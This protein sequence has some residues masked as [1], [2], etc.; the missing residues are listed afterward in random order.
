MGI[1]KDIALFLG[2]GTLALVMP[3]LGLPQ[4]AGWLRGRGARVSAADLNAVFLSAFLKT[5]EAR[6]LLAKRLARLPPSGRSGLAPDLRGTPWGPDCLD[7]RPEITEA[8]TSL[9]GLEPASWKLD[10]IL[11]ASARPDEL[12]DLFFERHV[13][14]AAAGVPLAGFSVLTHSQ[15]PPALYL[16]RR[17]KARYP[18]IKVCLGG[19]WATASRPAIAGWPELFSVVD[20]V[21]FYGGE[22]PLEGLI[23]HSKGLLPL[24]GIPNL[25]YFKDGKVRLTTL[26][27][28]PG[29][30]EI[31]AP[32]FG[33]LD[34]KLYARRM[35]PY[36][37]SAG[38]SW[39]RCTFCYHCFPRNRFLTRP[40]ETVVLEVERLKTLHGI[41]HFWFADLAVPFGTMGEI[42][43]LFIERRSSVLWTAMARADAKYTPEFAARLYASGCTNLFFGLETSDR[44]SL[45]RIDKGITQ[46]I[47]ERTVRACSG[48]GIT[49]SAFLLN[50]PGQTR[51]EYARTLAYVRG[52]GGA[53]SD[54]VAAR[55]ELGRSSNSM[56]HLEELGITLLPDSARDVRSF[57][58]PYVEKKRT[59]VPGAVVGSIRRRSAGRTSAA[60]EILFLRP[61]SFR[62]CGAPGAQVMAG[63]LPFLHSLARQLGAVYSLNTRV[64]DLAAG[65]GMSGDGIRAALRR[66]RPAQVY[67][68][69]GFVYDCQGV[70]ALLGICRELFPGVPLT[71]GG[72]YASLAPDDALAAGATRVFTGAFFNTGAAWQP[73][74]RTDAVRLARGCACGR[75]D[76]AVAALEGPR[77]L[78]R[79]HAFILKEARQCALAMAG[80]LPLLGTASLTGRDRELETLLKELCAAG[81]MA[82]EFP[83]GLPCAALSAEL[84]GLLGRSGGRG[85]A[86]ELI[87]GSVKPA[88]LIRELKETG[89]I[90]KNS[91]LGRAGTVIVLTLGGPGLSA[92]E[93]EENAARI[94]EKGFRIEPRLYAP[95][96]GSP[97]VKTLQKKGRLKDLADLNPRL[98]PLAGDEN[99][100]RRLEKLF[101]ELSAS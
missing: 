24:A 59:G 61:P 94:R 25:A 74:D 35:L 70:R 75:P 64:L 66:L 2:P 73:D 38:C 98:W 84:A 53:I 65:A 8:Y 48:A 85:A 3:E 60:G 83:E 4:L 50:Y 68:S 49:V 11:A 63:S 101:R 37:T 30:D 57:S 77:R 22:L 69:S 67:V 80:H 9:L 40:P 34:L 72:L 1:G 6:A 26:R 21:V 15:L 28:G 36:Q 90:L 82:A 19:P 17:L 7:G 55:F 54:A 99:A 32:D 71:A 14:P 97:E 39:G 96:P 46:E 76:C 52:L 33:D 58:L 86:L 56:R 92:E 43:R 87:P 89:K 81:G 42:S 5:P 12:Y 78:A 41:S 13:A 23:K 27:D 18:G 31:P 16:A 44:K 45:E 20:S 100:A 51:A 88:G 95:L 47:F 62:A 91:G 93:L 29:L 79:D 10:S